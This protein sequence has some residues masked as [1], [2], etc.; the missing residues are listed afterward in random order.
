MTSDDNKISLGSHENILLSTED[1]VI[2]AE[3]LQALHFVQCNYSFG[4]NKV[5]DVF[6]QIFL[7][8]RQLNLT[9]RKRQKLNMLYSSE[10]LP[11][12]RNR[13][14]ETVNCNHLALSL[15]EQI[16]VKWKNNMMVMSIFGP[17]RKKKLSASY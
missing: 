4:S 2:C 15:M 7:I 5:S 12:W 1:Q 16:Q 11:L 13:L 3:T 14:L 8:Q 17:L 9:N 6:K 10:L